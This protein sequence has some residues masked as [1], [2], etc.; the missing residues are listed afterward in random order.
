MVEP[1]MNVMEKLSREVARVSQLALRYEEIGAPGAFALAMMNA[2]L[3]KA[4]LAAGSGAAE[5]VIAAL[6]DLEGFTA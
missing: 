3:E 1:G 5:P 4:H 6:V 2:A